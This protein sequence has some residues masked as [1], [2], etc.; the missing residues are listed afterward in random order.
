MEVKAFDGSKAEIVFGMCRLLRKRV[1]KSQRRS[2]SIIKIVGRAKL[3]AEE[4]KSDNSRTIRAIPRAIATISQVCFF[5]LHVLQCTFL[6]GLY[7]FISLVPAAFL[8]E[9]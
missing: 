6:P 1:R 7:N 4:R 8:I 5:A 9:C 3:K 2:G